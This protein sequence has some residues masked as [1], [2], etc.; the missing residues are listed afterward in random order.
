M[1]DDRVSI[2]LL[3]IASTHADMKN[4]ILSEKL[5]RRINQRV[6]HSKFDIVWPEFLLRGIGPR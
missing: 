5:R 2:V 6:Q 4:M 1:L 3:Y